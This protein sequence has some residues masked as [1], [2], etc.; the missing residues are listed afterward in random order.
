MITRER[1][2]MMVL[3]GSVLL[4]AAMGTFHHRGWLL[5]LCLI[6]LNL[7]QSSVTG[8]CVFNYLLMKMGIPGERE[9]G[10]RDAMDG[11]PPPNNSVAPRDE[12]AEACDE[13]GDKLIAAERGR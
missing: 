6:G 13:I 9:V 7:V 2:A 1:I 10:W 5:V 4:C 3:G 12:S 8:K 11:L